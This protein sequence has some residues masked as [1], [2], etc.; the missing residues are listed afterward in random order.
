MHAVGSDNQK[1]LK[2]VNKKQINVI[3]CYVYVNNQED[4]IRR[5]F[6]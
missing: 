3:T 5:P 4:F 2:K 6:Y 1:K